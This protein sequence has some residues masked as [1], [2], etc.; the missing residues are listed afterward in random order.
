MIRLIALWIAGVAL[1][2]AAPLWAIIV[3][4]TIAPAAG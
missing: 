1:T 2:L 3:G 4:L